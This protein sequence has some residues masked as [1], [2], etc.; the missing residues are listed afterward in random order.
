MYLYAR[1]RYEEDPTIIRDTTYMLYNFYLN[2]STFDVDAGNVS[3]S[4]V[5]HEEP[6]L[7]LEAG[8]NLVDGMGGYVTEVEFTDEMIQSLANT[9]TNNLHPNP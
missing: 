6:T 4:V 5:E 1:G 9:Q 7:T 3:V 8:I 2:P